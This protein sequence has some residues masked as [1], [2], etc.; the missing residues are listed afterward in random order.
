LDASI[1]EKENLNEDTKLDHSTPRL[2][3]RFEEAL[4]FA[5][6]KHSGQTRKQSNVP[7]VAHLLGVTALVLEAGGDE[8]QAIAALLH[9]VVED[10]GGAPVL[11][12]VRHRFGERVAHIVDGLTDTDQHP[13]PPW[14][15]R[16][17]HYLRHLQQAGEDVRLVSV[18]DKLHNVRSIVSDYRHIG[19]AVWERFGGRRDGTLWYYRA[20]LDIFLQGPSNR[21]IE[22][23]E[24][25]V[26]ELERMVDR[27]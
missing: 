12:E 8:D 6:Q 10:C 24:R 21:L 1:C 22:E 27:L 2:G 17:D 3:A 26:L 16:K 23:L 20:L 5:T 19:E 13:K 18:A 15:A 11:D 4:V 7:Y 9:D 25:N 14:R